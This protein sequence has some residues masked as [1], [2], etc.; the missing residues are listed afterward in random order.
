[1]II[2]KKRIAIVL[3]LICCFFVMKGQTYRVGDLYTAPDGSQGIIFYVHPDGSGGWV[4]ALNDA[5]SGCQ[6]GEYTD[7]PNL[8]N[9]HPSYFMEV[10]IDTAGYANTRLIREFQGNSTF[11]ASCVDWVNGWYLPSPGQCVILCAQLPFISSAI[12]AAGGTNMASDR[13]W[14]SG[15]RDQSYAWASNFGVSSN[16]VGGVMA[17]PK[18][19]LARVRAVRSFSY[20]THQ[21]EL[22]YSW[23]TGDTTSDITVIPTQTTTYIV[24]VSTPGGC[25]DTVEHTIVVNSSTHEVEIVTAYGSFDWHGITY[26]TSDTYTYDYINSDGCPSTDTLHLTILH[27]THNVYD[28]TVCESYTWTEGDGETYTTSGTYTYNYTN[29]TGCAS[30]DTLHLTI[31]PIPVLNHT[32]DTVIMAGTSATLWA[33]GADILYWMDGNDSVLYSGTT[34]TINPLTTTAYYIN[35][36]NY[37]AG[38][39]NLVVNG[40]FEQGNVNFISDYLPLTSQ[41]MSYG[42]YTITTD[43]HL[44]F[45]SAHLYGYNGTGKFMLVDGA[46]SLNTVVWQQTVSVTPHTYY[47]FSAQVASTHH[48]NTSGAYALLQFSVN[49][50]QLGDIFHSPSVLNVWQPYYEVWYSGDNTTATLSILNQNTSLTGNDFGIDEISFSPLTECSVMDS[51]QVSVIYNVTDERSVC[52]SELPYVWN[53]VTFEHA[54]TLE[55]TLHTASGAD[56]VV[57]MYLTVLYGTHNVYDTTVCESYTWAEGDGETYTTSGVYTY[58][59]TNAAGCASADTLHLTILHG[60]HHVYDTTVCESYTWTEGD[61]ETYTTSGVY[62]YNYTNAAGC[63]SVDTLHLTILHGTHNVYDTT[64][65]ESYTWTEGDGETYT[66]SGTYTYNYTNADGCS[67]VDTLHLTILHGTHNVYDTTVCESYTWTEGD[68]ETYTTSGTYI[69]NYTNAAGCA[70]VDTLHLTIL[71]GTHHVYDTTVCESY[72]W[73]EGDGETYTTSGTYIYNYTNAAGCASADTLHLTILHGTH[74]VYDTTVCESYTWTEGDGE[75]YTTSG[76]YTYNYTN[77]AG[78][79]S[80]DTLHLTI[81]HGTH[82]VYD[83]TVCE[84]YTWTEGD[85]DTYTTS[86]VYTYNYTNAAGCSSADT[87]HLTILYGTHNV[88]DTTVCESYTWTEGDGETYT[89]SGTYTYNYT[90]VAGCSSADTL[91][92]TILNGTHNVYDTTVCESYTWTEGDGVTY[93]TSGTYTYNYTN[94]DGCSSADTLHLTILHGTHNVYDTTVCESY[95]WTEGDGE[96]YT[97]SGVYTYNYTNADGCLSADT[98]YLTILHGTHHVY[99]TAVCESYTWAEGDGETYTTSGTYTYNYTN[100]T[101]CASADTLHLTILYGTHNVY[102]TTVCESYTWTEGDG[103]TY[104][105]SGTYTY[106]YTNATG[107]ASA[108]TLHLTIL[109]GTHHVYDTAVCESYTWTEGDGETYTTS[110]TYTYN[111]TNAAGCASVD[112][113]HLT[114]LHG[115]HNVYDTTVCES[116]TWTEGD[117]ETYTTSGVYTYN[118]TS[119]AGCAS[120]DTLHLTILHGTHNVYDTTVCESYTWTEGDGETYTTSGTYIYNYTNAAGCASVDTLHLTILYG[121]HHVY[122]TTVCESYTWTEGDGETYTTSGVY[123]YNYTNAA[124]CSSADTLYLTINHA[125]NV[126]F[127]VDT[128]DDYMWYG[129]SY[130]TSGTYTYSHPDTNGCTQVD[131]LHLTI[132]RPV[133]IAFTVDTCDLYTWYGTTYTESGLYT[134][135]LDCQRVDT[136]YLQ[137]NHS[138]TSRDTLVLVENQLPYYFAAADTTIGSG[139]P[140]EFQFSYSLPSAFGCDSTIMQ[141]VIVHYN[142]AE[143][144]DTTVCFASL[145]Y[146]WYGHQFTQ[147]GTFNDTLTNADGSNHLITY[148]L[149][150]SNPAVTELGTNQVSCYGGADGNAEAVVTGGI[151]PYSC[152]WENVAGATVSTTGQLANQPAGTYTFYASDAIGCT[153]TQ[154]INLTHLSDSMVAGTIPQTQSVCRGNTLQVVVGTAASGGVSSVYQWQWSTNGV[155]WDA[156]PIPNNS[157]NYN[158]PNAVSTSFF[159]RR[160]WISQ[161]CGTVYSNVLSV[162]VLPI[163]ADTLQDAV[164]QGYAYQNNGFDISEAETADAT[165]VV[166]TRQLQSSLGCDSSVTLLLMVIAPQH[167]TIADG[168]CQHS[169]YQANGFDIAGDQL[170]TAGEYTFEQQYV[171]DNCDSVVTLH[172]TV[173]QE[174]EVTLQAVICEGDGYDQQG[175]IVPAAQTVGVGELDLTQVLQSQYACD[176][177]VNLHLTVVDTSIAIVSLTEDFCEEY[178][179]DL[180]VVTEATNYEWS[181]GET[182]PVITVTQ[183]GMYTVTATQDNCSISAWYQI[184]QCEFNVYLPNAITPGLGDGLNDYFCIH[185]QYKPMI[186]D[187]EIHIYSRWGELVYYSK[188]KD[189]KWEGVRNPHTGEILRNNIYTYLINFTD[190]RGVP[191]QLKGNI[192]VL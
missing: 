3:A 29:A 31:I 48:S 13:Y 110:G 24:T 65:C 187:F 95:T 111:Y 177:V 139:V 52:E 32:P 42:H 165:V 151:Q 16:Q 146:T 105:T 63:S 84:S 104:T 134:H 132:V 98:L 81:L 143:A 118:Y 47:A 162:S 46:T 93:T 70:S 125:T 7:I 60:T 56:S 128:C 137:L 150:V 148:Q 55:A 169:S 176:S 126:S 163:Y 91:H 40:D 21:P 173:Y 50:D 190:K 39:G 164:C 9:N 73:T 90:S 114:I 20:E 23:N 112:T 86:G 178:F 11:A 74:N 141:T 25:T 75:T 12:I 94:A 122:D 135:N 6:W 41:Y 185:D 149:N 189:F 53:G 192:T 167:T 115:T 59:Y 123:T 124:G 175:F 121:T 64:V 120:A 182:S 77:A 51:I 102:D 28:T 62:T 26:T 5:S 113:L 35:G 69:Y 15:E 30:A 103:E 168:I 157:Q 138:A 160:A 117:G 2:D 183:P 10:S 108:D 101:G 127:T 174:Y 172:L 109:Q 144:V 54:D 45:L 107:C 97:T 92:L 61:G 155:T 37:S 180:S 80:A 36:Y 33:S 67:S 171:V 89:T 161:A 76:V 85:G 191:Y 184:Q 19:T 140:A 58:N 154:T 38:S 130:D 99:D 87:L 82:N 159:L 83:T 100:A 147:A 71:Y 27:G 17:T 79:S 166:R 179:A 49:S 18:T 119:V 133:N 158:Y 156:A 14:S 96:T 129:I 116:Y 66:T 34:L 1:M 88:Y 131:T 186:E 4:V 188:D 181:T 44:H 153:T 142:T 145:P 152:H 68:G 106:N 170:A 22:S 136:L 72:T 43:G 57:V 8:A 78:C